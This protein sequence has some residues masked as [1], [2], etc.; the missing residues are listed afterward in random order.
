MLVL[1][2]VGSTSL[3]AQDDPFGEFQYND[4][5]FVMGVTGFVRLGDEKLDNETVVAAF[6]GDQLRGKC[7]P[8]DEYPY[9]S[10]IYLDVYS[11]K[12]G[13]KIHFKV[14]TG[15][16]VIEVD[17]GLTFE[18]FGVIGY[19]SDPY[20]IDL[21]VPVVTTPSAEGWAT[22]CLPFN[23]EV[24]DGVTVWNATGINN[25][26]LVMEKAQGKILPKNTPVLL[27]SNAQQ[28]DGPASYEWLSR[29][30]DGDVSTP[31]SILAGTTVEKTV[32]ANSVLTLGHSDGSG[33]IG[34]WL[35]TGTTIPAYRAYI[36]DFPSGSRGVKISVDDESTTG[37][38]DVRDKMSEVRGEYY[39]MQGCKVTNPTKG[40]Y[41]VNGRK[42]IVR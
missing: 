32:D 26:E 30:A 17:Q 40:L 5:Q 36:T 15:G 41:I 20:Y 11:N 2:L 9:T 18:S 22:T 21:P 24:P 25:G 23:A 37:V 19:P 12:A 13:E 31:G 34:F 3:M 1:L 28:A 27:Q 29:V 4:Y 42:I 16:R 33:E 6:C 7:N 10:I 14:F 38:A 35:F 8:M 39:N